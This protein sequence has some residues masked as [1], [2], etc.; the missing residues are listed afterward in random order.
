M[1]ELLD[2]PVFHDDQHGTA[3][4]VAAALRNSLRVVHKDIAECR[5][6]VSGVDAAGNAIIRLL[7]LQR[8][9]DIIACDMAGI[10]YRDRPGMDPNLAA[11]AEQT[12]ATGMTGS[13]H[14]AIDGA[15]VFIAVPAP[16][17]VNG[18]DV[19]RMS[20]G[21]VVFALADPDPEIDPFQ[22]QAHAAVV[23]T[24]RSDFPN[25][26]NNVLAFP[27]VFRGLL[28]AQATEI[29]DRMPPSL[30]DVVSHD[31]LNAS[32]IVPSVFDEN[33]RKRSRAVVEAAGGRLVGGG[34]KD[35]AQT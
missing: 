22:A 4:V 26:I 10:V 13:V 16:N 18:D 12:N 6:V 19:A 20:S 35:S 5:I 24:G 3:I 23:A 7:L 14:D 29:T 9:L 34:A 30:I 27:G 21:A 15:D 2:I 33:V 1:R 11:V 17:V 25:Q 32:Y 31:Q 28:D 8:P